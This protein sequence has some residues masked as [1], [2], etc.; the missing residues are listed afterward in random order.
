ML[1]R[2]SIR[3]L[4]QQ[5]GLASLALAAIGLAVALCVAVWQTNRSAVASFDSAAQRLQGDATHTI[6]AGP[7][8]ISPEWYAA[9]RRSG[10][11]RQ[12]S[13]KI[14]ARVMVTSTADNGSE[15]RQR[16]T[17]LGLDPFAAGELVSDFGFDGIFAADDLNAALRGEMIVFGRADRWPANATLWYGG[18][19]HQVRI[20]EADAQLVYLP[21]MLIADLATADILLAAT[22]QLTSIDVALKAPDDIASPKSE[23]R[24]NRSST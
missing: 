12:A 9:Q 21:D 2:S 3:H 4:W 16:A 22:G 15:K 6:Q 14:T 1:L 8:G 11:L 20:V 19:K 23:K 5:R 7:N 10:L 13:P 18:Q 24:R 17:L